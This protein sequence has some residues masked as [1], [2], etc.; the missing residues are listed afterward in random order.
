MAWTKIKLAAVAAVAL[1]AAPAAANAQKN[2]VWDIAIYGPP[3]EVTVPIEYLAKFLDEK[4]HGK[5]TL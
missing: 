1:L 2:I 4:T 3:R 5:F